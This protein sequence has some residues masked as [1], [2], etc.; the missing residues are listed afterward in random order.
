MAG[1]VKQQP[2]QKMIGFVAHDGAVRPLV[3]GFLPDRIKQRGSMIGGC[4]PGKIS[5]LYLTSP[6]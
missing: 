4:S 6:M 5:F 2:G 1:I 3:E